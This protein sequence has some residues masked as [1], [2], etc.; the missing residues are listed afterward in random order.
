MEYII[1]CSLEMHF[2]LRELCSASHDRNSF[3]DEIIQRFSFLSLCAF[4]WA[5][6]YIFRLIYRIVTSFLVLEF[7][8]KAK[9]Y[10]LFMAGRRAGGWGLRGPRNTLRHTRAHLS[11]LNCQES[12]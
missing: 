8:I 11:R 5:Y 6:S 7:E 12:R 10:Q 1:H 2:N 4:A 3:F 9:R